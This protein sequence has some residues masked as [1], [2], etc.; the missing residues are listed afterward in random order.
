[1]CQTNNQREHSLLWIKTYQN[2]MLLI[3]FPCD[4][5][6]RYHWDLNIKCLNI[7]LW[8]SRFLRADQQV[9]FILVTT[10]DSST[11]NFLVTY[12]RKWKDRVI[13][14]NQQS[15]WKCNPKWC[16]YWKGKLEILFYHTYISVERLWSYPNQAWLLPLLAFYFCQVLPLPSIWKY[17]SKLF[18]FLFCNLHKVI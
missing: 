12:T 16:C 15:S 9:L 13:L 8:N 14:F 3:N 5:I 7:N 1:M 17:N 11:W 10:K 2:R 4:Q 18:L 6:C